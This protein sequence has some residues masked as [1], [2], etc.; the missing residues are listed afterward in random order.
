[1]AFF[2]KERQW[3]KV[4]TEQEN[5]PTG[6]RLPVRPDRER[7]LSPFTLK[8]AKVFCTDSISCE[9]SH[10]EEIK[11]TGAQ[12]IEMEASTFYQLADLFDVPAIA[13]LVVSD[14][15]ATGMPLL[16]Q[17]RD[18]HERYSNTRSNVVPDMI[19][20]LAKE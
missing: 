4:E 17:N 11:A 9:Y 18:Q 3:L 10:L 1:M 2:V 6:C 8:T 15:S 20:R 14:N 16:G 13:L 7:V 19:V 12:L 5:H